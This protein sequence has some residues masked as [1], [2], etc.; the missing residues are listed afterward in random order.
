ML[1]DDIFP[2]PSPVQSSNV[3]PGATNQSTNALRKALKENNEKWHIF[4]NDDHFHKCVRV[5][6]R[7]TGSSNAIDSHTAHHVITLWALGGTGPV[8]EAAYKSTASYQRPIRP[9]E[10]ITSQNFNDHV[11]DERYH[12]MACDSAI[13]A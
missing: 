7:R 12:R 3:W 8:I 2:V 13:H 5:L 1:L 6:T 10:P 11:G 9:P 4:F